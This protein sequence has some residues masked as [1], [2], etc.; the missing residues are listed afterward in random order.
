MKDSNKID[1]VYWKKWESNSN[2]EVKEGEIKSDS[3]KDYISKLK[4]KIESKLNFKEIRIIFNG[5][6][7]GSHMG[8]DTLCISY[9]GKG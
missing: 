5:P 7:I 3:I 2:S 9:M 6:M 1:Y 4:E 8:A